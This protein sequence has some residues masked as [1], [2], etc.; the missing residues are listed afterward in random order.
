MDERPNKLRIALVSGAAIGAVSAIPGLSLINCC[1]CAGILLGGA[2]ATYLY[3]QELTETMPPAQTS[4]IVVLGL[5]AGVAGA[6]I[7]TLLELFITL[8]FGD[9][10]NQLVQ[11]IANRLIDYFVNSGTLPLSEADNLR[12]QIDD[13]VQQAQ[14]T[15]GF[16]SSLFSSLIIYPLF[17]MLG[18]LIGHSML[19][20]K[21]RP[22]QDLQSG[23]P[24]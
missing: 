18:A 9:V 20:R 10:G 7:G 1:C 5:A 17:S 16:F 23:M 8:A 19:K 14:G 11:S 13:A 12:G 2:L 3:R 4:D 15:S 21:D 24:Q 22:T 6:F